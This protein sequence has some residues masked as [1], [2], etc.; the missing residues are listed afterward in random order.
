M[1]L[2]SC[3]RAIAA[4]FTLLTLAACSQDCPST[5]PFSVGGNGR[6]AMVFTGHVIFAPWPERISYGRYNFERA[7]KLAVQVDAGFVFDRHGRLIDMIASM[8][9]GDPSAVPYAAPNLAY[10]VP[11]VSI[12]DFLTEFL[13]LSDLP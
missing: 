2:I 4:A 5:R 9:I 1:C 6:Q 13:R 3:A 12:A 7:I 10:A 8:V 11:A